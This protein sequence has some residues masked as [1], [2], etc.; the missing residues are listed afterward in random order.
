MSAKGTF[1]PRN[2]VMNSRG[3]DVPVLREFFKTYWPFMRLIS[4]RKRKF[5]TR[6]SR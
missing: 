5:R 3:L 2:K 6:R 4:S 1:V